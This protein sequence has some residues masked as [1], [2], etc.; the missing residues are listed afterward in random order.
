MRGR[1][2]VAGS[3]VTLCD[4]DGCDGTELGTQVA[5]EGTFSIQVTVAENDTTSLFAFATDSLGN[6]SG[7]V[8]SRHCLHDETGAPQLQFR[9]ANEEAGRMRR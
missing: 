1:L 5:T 7:F 3:T 8:A 6:E 4:T 2:S 9:H